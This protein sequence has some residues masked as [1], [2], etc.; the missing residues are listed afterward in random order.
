MSRAPPFARITRTQDRSWT[1]RLVA[2]LADPALP[3]R[4]LPR[5]EA[6]LSA[7]A[8]GRARA[9]LT[10]L[11]E[12]PSAPEPARAVASRLLPG[13]WDTP[14]P[15]TLRAWWTQGDLLLRR[16]ALLQMDRCCAD[17]LLPVADDPAHPLHREALEAMCFG[18]PEAA[19]LQRLVRG[20]EHPDPAVRRAAISSLLYPEPWF[21]EDAL[22]RCAH[23]PDPRV[24]Q[25]A[26]EVLGY[27]PTRRC[28]RAL[29]GLVDHPD[30]GVRSE[31]ETVLRSHGRSFA[32][33]LHR[34]GDP[35]LQDWM[36]PVADLLG[37][38]S[39]EPPTVYPPRPPPVPVCLAELVARYGDPDGS[40]ASAQERF[41][42]DVV[43]EDRA[44]AVRFLGAHPDA[45]VHSDA[46][47]LLA[48]LDAQEVL[49]TLTQDP[50]F[51]VR[52]SATYY[53]GLT[54]PD[55]ALAPALWDQLQRPEVCGTHAYETLVTWAH[56]APPAEPVARL[57]GLVRSDVREEVRCTAVRELVRAR[58]REA[59][60][61]L[62]PLLD[63]PPDVTWGLHLDLLRAC[64]VLDID[65]GPLPGLRE[66]DHFHVQEALALLRF[67]APG[68]RPDPAP[69][70]PPAGR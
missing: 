39:L 41:P 64:E 67:K 3:H 23:D 57:P 16:H 26:V 7:L 29:A 49:V 69:T 47:R 25:E 5:L 14:S 54:T 66:V 51:V 59:V 19:H 32:E 9:P 68:P 27:Y 63:A 33:L 50:I 2:R 24:A 43:P 61:A 17:L 42:D 30:A 4:E 31:V 12:D 37:T 34:H 46:C 36:A 44:E 58:A 20:T 48:A 56:H 28:L 8:D 60:D 62:L 13:L 6:A 11:L 55:P 35:P 18:F 45:G 70:P 1:L 40:W 53:L 65:P 15:A 22:L 38:V 52:K 21:A 10:A